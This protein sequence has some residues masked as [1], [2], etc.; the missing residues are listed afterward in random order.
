MPRWSSLWTNSGNVFEVGMMRQKEAAK[1]KKSSTEV[2][3][4][5]IMGEDSSKSEFDGSKLLARRTADS[6]NQETQ[7]LRDL[8]ERDEYS[9]RLRQ[10]DDER[11]RKV[12]E[13]EDQKTFEEAAK[14][15]Q[16]EKEDR[17]K[18]FVKYLVKRKDDKQKELEADIKDDEYFFKEEDLIE[19]ER[20]DCKYKRSVL[21]LAKEYD[22]VQDAENEQRYVTPDEK[23]S[24]DDRDVEVDEREKKRG[25]EQKKWRKTS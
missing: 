10:R 9:E 7:R 21:K 15:L 24:V 16:L 1:V 3:K 6:D 14:R 8:Q 4:K 25:Y 19:R 23:V 12:A 13:K 11:T 22:P 18:V 17:E 5:N 2:V 20:K